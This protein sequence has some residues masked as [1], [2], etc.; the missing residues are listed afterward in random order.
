MAVEYR[1]IQRVEFRL[2]EGGRRGQ[3][4]A[5]V[6]RYNKIDDYRTSFRPGVFTRS[7]EDHLPKMVWGHNFLEPI[8]QWV[9]ADDKSDRLR[10]LGQL[11]LEMVTTDDGRELDIPAVPMAHRAFVQL[12]KRTIDQFSV[13]FVRLSDS[14]HPEVRGATQIDEAWLDEASPVLVGSVPG[15]ALVGVRS[16]NAVLS[17]ERSGVRRRAFNVR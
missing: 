7:L 9:D 3:V 15:T 4:L 17:E 13:G 1:Q 12:Q 14:P 5:D 16:R 6:I 10:M 2:P 8:G 11:D